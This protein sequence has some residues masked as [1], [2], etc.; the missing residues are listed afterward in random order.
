MFEGKIGRMESE[1]R[2]QESEAGRTEDGSQMIKK[3]WRGE[4]T[5][6]VGN[7][8]GI[9]WHLQSGASMKI[10]MER[11]SIMHR[12]MEKQLEVRF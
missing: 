1:D 2:S 12:K 7:A 9:M 11:Q 3:P 10:A 4:R 8:P 5:K 6:P